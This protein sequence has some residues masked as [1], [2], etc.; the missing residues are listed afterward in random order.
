LRIALLEGEESRK[1]FVHLVIQPLHALV[2][3]PG[4]LWGR[5]VLQHSLKDGSRVAVWL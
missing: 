4:W 3:V 5:Q 1:K 2:T